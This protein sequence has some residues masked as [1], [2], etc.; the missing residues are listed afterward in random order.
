VARL[1]KAKIVIEAKQVSERHDAD[2]DHIGEP[3]KACSQPWPCDA[4]TLARLV[5]TKWSTQKESR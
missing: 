4:Y 1:T 3:C 5:V 2:D